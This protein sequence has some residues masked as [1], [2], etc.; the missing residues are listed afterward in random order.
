MTPTHTV[1]RAMG[2]GQ[3]AAA[4]EG[5]TGFSELPRQGGR[6][7]PP[8]AVPL[9][10]AQGWGRGRIL[11]AVTALRRKGWV[12]QD[13]PPLSA[14]QAQVPGGGGWGLVPRRVGIP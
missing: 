13:P 11:G 7:E 10:H 14:G 8:G 3:E 2:W 9:P 6:L 12:S 4:R 5:E 1:P